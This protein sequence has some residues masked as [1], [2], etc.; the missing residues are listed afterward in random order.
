MHQRLMDS[1]FWQD[2]CAWD[3]RAYFS[4]CIYINCC[5]TISLFSDDDGVD[6]RRCVST[7]PPFSQLLGWGFACWVR[8]K[9]IIEFSS[10]TSNNITI[11]LAVTFWKICYGSVNCSHSL[12]LHR[13]SE[14][15]ASCILPQIFIASWETRPIIICQFNVNRSRV[16]RGM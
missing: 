16:T 1:C 6:L 14:P 12:F 3:E 10:R 15:N 2:L 7:H 5:V 4:T 13:A 9:H 8:N 11:F